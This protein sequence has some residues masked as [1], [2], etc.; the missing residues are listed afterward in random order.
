MGADVPR[1]YDYPHPRLPRPMVRFAAKKK[2]GPSILD[3]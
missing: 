2:L 1:G 3:P